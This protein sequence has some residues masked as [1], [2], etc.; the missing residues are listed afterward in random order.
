M[1][2]AW[3]KQARQQSSK[4]NI[5]ATLLIAANLATNQDFFSV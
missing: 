2:F 3:P 5:A 4:K 1:T